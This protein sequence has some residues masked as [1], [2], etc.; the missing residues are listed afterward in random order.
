M[1]RYFIVPT[2]TFFIFII[3]LVLY[4]Q[5]I[6]NEWKYFYKAEDKVIPEYCNDK[7]KNY[8]KTIIKIDRDIKPNRSF[9]DK[10]DIEENNFHLIYF[11][12]CDQISRN[13]DINKKIEKTIN[14]INKWF[15]KKSNNQQL[16]FDHKNK[17]L[18]I[19]FIRVNKTLSWFN[20]FNSRQNS[21][22]DN[23]SRIEKIIL[24]NKDIFNN[25]EVKKFI[26][27][28]EGWE[29]RKSFFYTTCG[30]ARFGGKVAVIYTNSDFKKK[31]TC[32]DIIETSKE[33]LNGEEQTVLH[34]LLHLIGFPKSCSKNKDFDDN[35]H[36]NDSE[37]DILFKF[38]GSKYLDFNNDDYYNHNISKCP[39]LKDSLYLV[40]INNLDNN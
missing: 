3:L 11:V 31:D 26:V 2:F 20:T 33:E 40:N 9:N 13:F 8:K 24:S 29:K 25:F 27:F 19:T 35:F 12:P 14:N 32:V 18:D 4:F 1:H 30:R 37:D 6:E 21:S 23:S 36:I 10:L 15:F 17:Q 28:F 38:S 16:K 34:E 22:D 39:D 5:F 7:S